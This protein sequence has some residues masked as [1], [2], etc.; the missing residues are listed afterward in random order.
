MEKKL[1]SNLHNST[2]RHY[3]K[4][5][6]DEKVKCMKIAKKYS[7]DY[8]DGDRRYGYGGYKYI[9]GRWKNV[10][11]KLIKDYKLKKGSK[12]LDVGCGKSYLLYEM[13]LI[14]PELKIFGI[15]IS[16]HA[17]KKSIKTKNLNLSKKD[18]RKKLPYA[19]KQ[20]D[21]VI[22]LATLHNFQLF[23]LVRAIKEI[24]RVGKKK[25]IMVE[26]Y[27]TNLELFNLQCWALT[28]ETFFSK[29]EWIYL[30][31]ELKYKGDYE[32]IYFK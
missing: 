10:A 27:K 20:F 3:L 11:K 2:K 21:L 32:F 31:D 6:I 23:D 19:D 22:S 16:N 30:F 26:S 12:V 1:I 4:R 18:A 15:D 29:K 8:W 14:E 9:S 17:L 25:F 28:C 13:L 5:M 24:E 7:I